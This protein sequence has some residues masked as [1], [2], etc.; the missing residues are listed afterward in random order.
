MRHKLLLLFFLAFLISACTEHVYT[1]AR[2]VFREN[3]IIDYLKKHPESYS[4]YTDLLYK[5]PVS[6]LGETTVGQLLS[7]RG[8]YTVFAPTNEAIRIYLDTLA[9]STDDY[10][11]SAPSWDAFTDSTKLDSI[12]KTIVLTALESEIDR[13]VYKLYGLTEEEIK[14]IEEKE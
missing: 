9:A 6:P 4:I 3:T 14:I 8:H 10:Y 1:S 5:V 2:Y 11:I 7:A 12:R 13:L